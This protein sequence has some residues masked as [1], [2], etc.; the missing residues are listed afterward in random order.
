MFSFF[1]RSSVIHLDCFTSSNDAYKFAP[2]VYSNQAK[3]EWYDGV[4]K[5]QPTNTKWPQF[6]LNEDGNIY[7]DW[8]ISI[9]TVRACPGFHELYKRGFMLE[10]WCD[11]V[12][13]VN[14]TG[15]ISYNF[16]NGKAPILHGYHQVDPG[17][18][19]HHILKLN[20]PWI[21]QSKEDVQFIVV[22]AQWSL[23]KYNFHI[24]P[25]MVNF[26][27]QTGSNVF[28]AIHKF[29]QDQFAIHMGQ[30]LVQFIPLSDKNIKIHNHI[31]TEAELTTK[32]YSVIGRSFG[33]RKNVSLVKRNDRRENKKC[34]FGFGE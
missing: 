28:L 17:F 34:P 22:P 14:G 33:W 29:K 21:I 26:H 9:R 2:I 13:N 15:D 19:D 18:K 10:N 30:P 11:F 32:T 5:P 1:H 8:N 6:K 27:H 3:P 12:V 7:F 25:G 20:S 4:L 23:E 24:L 31:V 16:S